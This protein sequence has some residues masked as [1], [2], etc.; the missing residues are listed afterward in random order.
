[1]I[2]NSNKIWV[3]ATATNNNLRAYF[4]EVAFKTK[5]LYFRRFL[6]LDY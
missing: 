3:A 4:P 2:S 6:K 5:G 1:M